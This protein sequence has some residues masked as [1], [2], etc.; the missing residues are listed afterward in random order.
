MIRLRE[1]IR[2]LSVAQLPAAVEQAKKVAKTERWEVLTELGRRWAEID[3]KGAIAFG[4]KSGSSGGYNSFLHGAVAA[5]S[6]AA[7]AEAI[8]WVNALPPGEERS[9]LS[10]TLITSIGRD[11]PAAAL[12]LLQRQNYTYGVMPAVDLFGAWTARNPQAAAAAALGLTGSLRNVALGEVARSW[13]QDDTQEALAWANTIP[14]IPSRKDVLMAIT[15]QWAEVDPRAVIRW[16]GNNPDDYIGRRAFAEGISRLAAVDLPAA[17]SEIQAL[18]AGNEHDQAIITAAQTLSQTDA[19]SALPLLEQLAPGSQRNQAL[20]DLCEVWGAA[21]PRAAL[22]Y[23][24][25]NAPPSSN[26]IIEITIRNWA[27]RA[28]EEAIAWG[29]AL[30]DGDGRDAALAAMVNALVGTDFDGA[31][32]LFEQLSAD[33]QG[34]A[35]DAMTRNLVQQDVNQARQWA[36]ALPQGKARNNA[37][38][39]LASQWAYDNP[40]ATAQWLNGL[41]SGVARDRAVVGFGRATIDRDPDSALTWALTITDPKVRADTIEHLVWK[42]QIADASAARE[43]LG[44]STALTVDQK[45]R[46]LDR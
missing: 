18:P 3:L 44:A 43:W 8:S 33:G 2:C 4:L 13:A 42:W 46:I 12:G 20:A 37:L 29:T 26:S 7:P 39:I 19:L 27:S 34:L 28:P 25:R 23:L 17:L 16:A 36:E 21:D 41:P 30:P 9:R 22:D 11:D 32:K 31:Q 6:R 45:R 40:V 14:N 15:R 10:G 35:A 24:F 38:E 5:W 1:V